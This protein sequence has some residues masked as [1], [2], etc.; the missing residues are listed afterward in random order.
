[1]VNLDD[2]LKSVIRIIPSGKR[3]IGL[4]LNVEYKA[5]SAEGKTAHGL[6]PVVAILDEE[7]DHQ[8]IIRLASV[9]LPEVRHL[10]M[11]D[12]AE[13]IERLEQRQEMRA[14]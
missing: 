5:I 7:P 14:A 13:R 2:T 4:P 6:S 3:L 12:L 1:M 8:T 11:L 10:S 9:I